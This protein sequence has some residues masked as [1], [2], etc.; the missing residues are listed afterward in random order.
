MQQTH[1]T[2][3][4]QGDSGWLINGRARLAADPAPLSGTRHARSISVPAAMPFAA[5]SASVFGFAA[6]FF[7]PGMLATRQVDD[8]SPNLFGDGLEFGFTDPAAEDLQ[9]NAFDRHDRETGPAG[10]RPT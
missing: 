3:G 7:R 8:F 1:L 4:V 10:P 5:A 2:Q 6:F 9:V